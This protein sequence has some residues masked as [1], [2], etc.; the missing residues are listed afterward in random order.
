[1]FDCTFMQSDVKTL[2]DKAIYAQ[3][4]QREGKIIVSR[5]VPVVLLLK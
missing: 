4:S 5:C 2:L 1:M 3:I